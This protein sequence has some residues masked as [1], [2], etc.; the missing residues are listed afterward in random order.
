MFPRHVLPFALVGAVCGPVMCPIV[1]AMPAD[2]WNWRAAFFIIVPP[3]IAT[4]FCIWI[5]LKD[6]TS[7]TTLRFDWIGFLALSTALVCVSS[8]G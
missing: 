7:G 8:H 6:H 1:G 4:L 5:A 3:G 2:A